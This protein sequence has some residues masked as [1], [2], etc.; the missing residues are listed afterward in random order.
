MSATR[1]TPAVY[2]LSVTYSSLRKPATR[3]MSCSGWSVCP[4]GCNRHFK[5]IQ[6]HIASKHPD[7]KIPKVDGA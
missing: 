2:D 3:A 5:N 7:F 1:T 6:D 4:A